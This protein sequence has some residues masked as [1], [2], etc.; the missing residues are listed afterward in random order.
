[1]GFLAGKKI[2]FFNKIL[3]SNAKIIR[4]MPNLPIK[5]SQGIFPYYVNQNLNKNEIKYLHKIFNNFVSILIL[6]K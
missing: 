1:M 5:E 3:G 4:S 2:A 6:I